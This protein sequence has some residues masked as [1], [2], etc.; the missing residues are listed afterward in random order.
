MT[1]KGFIFFQ[2]S[3]MMW[4]VVRGM[5]LFA[6]GRDYFFQFVMAAVMFAGIYLTWKELPD[7]K[8]D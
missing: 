3:I 5:L 8:G 1:K 4:Y 7:E 6:N 2:S